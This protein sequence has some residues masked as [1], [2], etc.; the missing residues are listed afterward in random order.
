M[1]YNHSW[2]GLQISIPV[3]T[4]LFFICITVIVRDI[5]DFLFLPPRSQ[6]CCTRCGT[7]TCRM[8]P[9]IYDCRNTEAIQSTGEG[10]CSF[11]AYR[12]EN[13]ARAEGQKT[14]KFN[15][16]FRKLHSFSSCCWR[17]PMLC[18]S[19]T[20]YSQ[21]YAAEHPL[22]ICCGSRTP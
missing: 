19:V 17:E 1:N 7:Q 3:N 5:L 11:S 13:Q 20:Y 10:V 18:S 12:G 6:C 2:L 9:K 14:H 15:R 21:S 16:W 8:S 4:P 22:Y